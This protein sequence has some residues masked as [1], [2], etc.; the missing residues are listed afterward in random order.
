MTAL[1][2]TP[3][4]RRSNPIDAGHDTTVVVIVVAALGTVVSLG[5]AVGTAL[6][7]L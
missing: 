3:Q 2:P 5:A 7:L 6:G 1:T 4:G